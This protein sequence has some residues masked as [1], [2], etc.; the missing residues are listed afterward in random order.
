[1]K[2]EVGREDFQARHLCRYYCYYQTPE[3]FAY[4]PY[5]YA[6]CQLT[7]LCYV[8]ENTSLPRVIILYTILQHPRQVSKSP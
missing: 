8:A 6:I 7:Q 5:L 3:T 4:T 2:L 1:M